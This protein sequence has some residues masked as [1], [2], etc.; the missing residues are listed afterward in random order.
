MLL[1][2]LIAVMIGAVLSSLAA[3]PSVRDVRN[4]K[5]YR[6][7]GRNYTRWPTPSLRI[8]VLFSVVLSFL[9]MIAFVSSLS[10]LL[11]LSAL[12]SPGEMV[13]D[14]LFVGFFGIWTFPTGYTIYLLRVIENQIIPPLPQ[15]PA[16]VKA[17]KI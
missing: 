4:L 15:F 13:A 14:R 1:G 5:H 8:H 10:L 3:L 7:S 17:L 2:Y 11:I 9:L 12:S 16:R 6:R